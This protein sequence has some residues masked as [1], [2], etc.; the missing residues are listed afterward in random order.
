MVKTTMQLKSTL[1]NKL[2]VII[3]FIHATQTALIFTSSYRKCRFFVDQEWLKSIIPL[4][5]VDL[6]DFYVPLRV[7]VLDSIELV[8]M[9]F[10]L[11]LCR[12]D[13][14]FLWHGKRC[15][16]RSVFGSFP[17]FLGKIVNQDSIGCGGLLEE[18]FHMGLLL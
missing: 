18:L 11:F 14:T 7:S 6:A 3:F 2:V 10:G 5:V 15:R 1:I 17:K 12:Q 13:Q 9:I 4:I 8:F 16:S